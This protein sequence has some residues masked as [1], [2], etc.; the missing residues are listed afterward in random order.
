[1]LWFGANGQSKIKNTKVALVG[2]G[3]TGSHVLQQLAYLGINNITLIDSDKVSETNL[4]RIVGSTNKDIGMLKVDVGKRLFKSISTQAIVETIDDTFISEKG[5]VA[6][7]HSDFIFGC[8]DKDG[9]RLLLTELSKAY[10]KP[11]LDIATEI[12]RDGWGGRI[13]FSDSEKGCLLCRG[14]LNNDEIRRDLS[15]PMDRSID[16]KVY[17]IPNSVL[18]NVSPAVISLNG[19]LASLGVTEFLVYITEIRR[20]KRSL[21]YRGDMGIVVTNL[22]APKEDCYYCNAINGIGDKVDMDKYIRQGINKVL[23]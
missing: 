7:I 11:Y 6:L 4:N 1:M 5:I 18:M 8:I 10:N 3:G 14:E 12:N 15:S 22:N 9:G 17:G 2:A 20:I 16:D 23:R 13:V 19:I 21:E